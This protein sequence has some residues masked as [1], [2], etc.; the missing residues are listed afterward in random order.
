MALNPTKA[1]GQLG[2]M[3]STQNEMLAKLSR[4]SPYYRRNRPHVCSFWVKGEC[5]RGEECPYRH[6]MP[7]DP[8][9][10][11][12]NQNIKDRYYGVNDPVADKLV[13]RYQDLH[14]EEKIEKSKAPH[15]DDAHESGAHSHTTPGLP[16]VLPAPPTE[17]SNDF[18]GLS[19][20]TTL[21]PPPPPPPP[22]TS[23]A[24][25]SVKK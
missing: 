17:I 20:F 15:P 4:K 9:D 2:K 14:K 10:P 23:K 25:K 3:P 6:E 18:F 19:S 1:F 5:K 24:A 13:K 16:P 8:E 21:I 11:L 7:N 12:T 22:S